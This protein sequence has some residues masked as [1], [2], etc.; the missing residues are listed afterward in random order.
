MAKLNGVSRIA[1]AKALQDRIRHLEQ[2]IAKATE[3]LNTGEHAHWARFR[4]LFIHKHRDG[5][6]LP[7]HRDWVRNVF[8]PRK[9]KSLNLAEQALER[10]TQHRCSDRKNSRRH[11]EYQST[12]NER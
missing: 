10:I 4:P 7:P 6:E 1:K 2:A 11:T 9:Q 5:K 3:F 12:R 8:I